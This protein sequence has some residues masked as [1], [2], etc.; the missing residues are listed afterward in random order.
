MHF[1]IFF[2]PRVEE[3]HGMPVQKQTYSELKSSDNLVGGW[4]TQFQKICSSKWK[5]SP[6]GRIEDTKKMKP[7]PSNLLIPVTLC[8]LH[9]SMGSVDLER[10]KQS[11]VYVTPVRICLS[12]HKAHTCMVDLLIFEIC[13]TTFIDFAL[14]ASNKNHESKH[15]I[16]FGNVVCCKVFMRNW[17]RTCK[18]NA[19]RT[20]VTTTKTLHPKRILC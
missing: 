12:L 3:P 16:F 9:V 10:Y 11:H 5:K 2:P 14:V 19:A 13:T 4:E 18:G 17:L 7:P 20:T 15:V 6:Q 1:Y 8:P